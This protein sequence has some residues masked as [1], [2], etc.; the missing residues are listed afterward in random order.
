[1][2]PGHATLSKSPVWGESMQ[3]KSEVELSET[4][5][6]PNLCETRGA[7]MQIHRE[8]MHNNTTCCAAL[9]GA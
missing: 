5:V 3:T 4:F 9:S 2:Q 1:M 7:S 6:A 8:D